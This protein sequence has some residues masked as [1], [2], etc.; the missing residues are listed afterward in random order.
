MLSNTIF[1]K[2]LLARIGADFYYQSKNK[3]YRYIASAAAFA[4]TNENAGNNPIA[5]IFI[6]GRIKNFDFFVKAEYWNSFLVLDPFAT[7]FNSSLYEPTVP[8]N[9]KLGINWRFFN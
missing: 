5:D 1:K 8:F 9:V 3:A 7:T 4:L 2:A 6:N